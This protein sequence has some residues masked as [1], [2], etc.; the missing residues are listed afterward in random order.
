MI[1]EIAAIVLA[2][3]LGSNGG[4]VFTD[5]EVNE[6]FKNQAQVQKVGSSTKWVDVTKQVGRTHSLWLEKTKDNQWELRG[7]M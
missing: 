4:K 1:S 7:A 5:S 3:A 2:S 6:L